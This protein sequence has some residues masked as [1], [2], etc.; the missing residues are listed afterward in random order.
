[1]TKGIEER[2]PSQV[3]I[4]R[5]NLAR[6]KYQDAFTLR[7][8]PNAIRIRHKQLAI[9]VSQPAYTANYLLPWGSVRI[10]KRKL[11]DDGARGLAVAEA[12]CLYDEGR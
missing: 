12:L 3:S 9:A 8:C 10:S 2:Y 5:R 1:M 11:T 7:Q 6:I 4:G